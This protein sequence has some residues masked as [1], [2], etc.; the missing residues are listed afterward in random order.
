MVAAVVTVAVPGYFLGQPAAPSALIDS[1]SKP[2][3]AGGPREDRLLWS[4]IECLSPPTRVGTS[5]PRAHARVLGQKRGC[6]HPRRCQ[7]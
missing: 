6:P 5:V 1:A 3:A 7:P 4:A 2:A